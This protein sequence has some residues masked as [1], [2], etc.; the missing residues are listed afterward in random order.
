MHIENGSSSTGNNCL[1]NMD[2]FS[3]KIENY[4]IPIALSLLGVVLIIGG[5]V[6]SNISTKKQYP[7]ESIVKASSEITV[8]I[9]GAVLTPGVYRLKQGSIVEDA[10]FKAGGF[11]DNANVEFI[12]KYLNMAR[13]IS[14]GSKIYVPFVGEKDTDLAVAKDVAGVSSK[15]Q[16]DLNNGSSSDLERLPGIGPVSANK[17]ISGR[18]Y[19]KVEELLDK[20]IIGKAVFEKIK[21]LLTIN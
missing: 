11:A 3:Q 19:Q 7:K 12:S 8:D 2:N 4:K 16:V 18:P 15:I 20:K 6:A 14:D 5:I 9:S 21:D 13:K 17:I 1:P 10:I